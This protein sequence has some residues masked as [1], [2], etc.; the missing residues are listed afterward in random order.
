M[1]DRTYVVTGPDTVFSYLNVLEPKAPSAGGEAKYKACLIIPKSDKTTLKKI[2]EAIRIA[3]EEGEAKLRGNGNSVP[4]LDEI[5]NPLHDGDEE[6]SGDPAFRNAYFINASNKQQPQLYDRN[7]NKITDPREL[8]S[9]IIGRAGITFYAFNKGVKSRGITCGLEGI[10]KLK[11]GTPLGGMSIV[12]DSFE[13]LD[14][15]DD[16]DEDFLG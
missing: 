9:G 3:Y 8:Y 16:G 10:K 7:L 6:R 15:E 2:R 4:P 14:D 11:D 13:G 12:R 1:S 5:F